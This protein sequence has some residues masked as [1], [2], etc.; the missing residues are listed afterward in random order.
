MTGVSLP[1][2]VLLPGQCPTGIDDRIRVRRPSHRDSWL[3]LGLGLR[4]GLDSESGPGRITQVTIAFEF[5]LSYHHDG[6]SAA[7]MHFQVGLA[8]A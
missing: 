4:V 2:S 1:V 3:G 5:S 7:A 6:P 8:A